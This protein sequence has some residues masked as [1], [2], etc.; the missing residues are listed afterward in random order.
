MPGK[1]TGA[2]RRAEKGIGGRIVLGVFAPGLK[3][4]PP[5]EGRREDPPGGITERVLG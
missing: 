4:R 5:E 3:P 2:W 1:I